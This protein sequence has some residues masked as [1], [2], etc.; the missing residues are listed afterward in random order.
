MIEPESTAKTKALPRRKRALHWIRRGHLYFGLFLFP[1]A[2]L[3]GV[4][5]FLFNHPT[6]FGDRPIES[7][8]PDALHGTLLDAIPSPNEQAEEVV[9]RLNKMKNPAVPYRVAGEAKYNREFAFA[10]VIVT[11]P[12]QEQILGILF[13]LKNRRGTVRS[14]LP[15]PKKSPDVAPFAIGFG[16]PGPISEDLRLVVPLPE[17]VKSAIPAILQNTGFPSGAITVTSVPD[18]VFPIEADGRIWTAS[19]NA[20]AGSLGG[21][22]GE[23]EK[24]PEPSTRGFLTRLH[25]THGYPGEANA[26]WFWGILVDVMAFALC[27]W[28]CTGLVMWWQ[29]KAARRTGVVVLILSAAAAVALGWAMYATIVGSI[30]AHS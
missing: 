5:A 11:E 9:A 27:F 24:K 30:L 6:A 14:S 3:Y 20:T 4:T 26:G 7:F 17:R 25:V 8:G 22:L 16:V 15:A 1:W 19:Y 2:L 29:I 12:G 23:P 21:K 13:D 10:T 28:G 18:L